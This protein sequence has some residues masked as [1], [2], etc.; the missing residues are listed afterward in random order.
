ML[1][2]FYIILAILREVWLHTRTE[3]KPATNRTFIN[4]TII[5][6]STTFVFADMPKV[7]LFAFADMPLTSVLYG[8]LPLS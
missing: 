5:S 7:K 1:H 8:R 2:I 4:A 6:T 3:D